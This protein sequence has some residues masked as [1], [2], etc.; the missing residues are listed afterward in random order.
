MNSRLYPLALGTFAIGTGTFVT[1]GLVLPVSRSLGVSQA[2]AGQ[3]VTVFA[4]AYAL[5]SPILAAFTSKVS[6][7]RVLLVAMVVFVVGNVL[8]ALAPTFSLVLATRLLAAAGAALFTPTASAVATALAPPERR[9]SALAVVMGGLTVA[10]A[11]GVPL[12]TWMGTALSWRATLWLVVGLGVLAL[13][14]VAAAVPDVQLGVPAGLRDRLAPLADR[15]VLTILTTQVFTFAAAFTVYTYL[16]AMVDVPLPAVLWAWGIGGI[17]GN[18]FGGRLT[19]AYGPRRMV[20]LG[21]VGI[22]VSVA[23]APV[24]GLTLPA[25]LVWA[26]LWGALGWV[27]GPSQ[28]YRMVAAVADNVS[29][30]LGLLAATQYVGIFLA[31]MVGGL[32]LGWYGRAGVALLATAFGVF[33]LLFTLATYRRPPAV[34]RAPQ[35]ALSSMPRG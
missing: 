18:L 12:G 17:A 35:P 21:I 8:T 29:V 9:G 30:G 34:S 32:T 13:V 7:R 28:Q 11:L 1:A 31:G 6:R 15:G 14:G 22:T 23:L 5:L 27:I 33:A 16:G 26:F 4:V 25:A 2:A 10:T 24:A 3:L 20:F 19:D